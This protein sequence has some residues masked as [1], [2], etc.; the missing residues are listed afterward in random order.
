[1]T[2]IQDATPLTDEEYVIWKGNIEI[3]AKVKA[4]PW[5]RREGDGFVLAE[6]KPSGEMTTTVGIQLRL[7]ATIDRLLAELRDREEK[8]EAMREWG[9]QYDCW[10]PE[11]QDTFLRI[12]EGGK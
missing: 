4:G 8:L 9:R 12:L 1:M 5:Y 2:R 11:E 10:T 7:F 6:D 3:I